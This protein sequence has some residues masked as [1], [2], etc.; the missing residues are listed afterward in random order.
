MKKDSFRVAFCGMIS[1]LSLVLMLC[2]TLI[3]VGTYALPCIAGILLTAVVVEFGWKWALG[4][5]FAVSALSLFLAGDKE[6]VAY[7]IAFFGFYPI[8]KSG[9]ERIRS[10]AVQY[11]IKYAL[12]TVC[13]IAA[14][15][16]TVSVLMIPAEEFTIFGVY[17]PWV[18]LLAAELVFW[19]YDRC[20]TI[21]VTRYIISVRNKMFH[22]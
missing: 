11:I 17:L 6:A 4:A 18:F 10:I 15:W 20:I 16:V 5:F 1:A 19:F 12:F 2:T 21:L 3:P 13:M 8:A 14:F 9:I 7:F 22:F